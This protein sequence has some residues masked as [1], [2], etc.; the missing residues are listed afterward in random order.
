M[1]TK[2]FDERIYLA[3]SP[4]DKEEIYD[5]FLAGCYGEIDLGVKFSPSFI[6]K[7]LDLISYNCGLYDF[8]D[9]DE[10]YY[11]LD[12]EYY[13]QEEVNKLKHDMEDEE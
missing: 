7:N 1:S 11:E 6:L 8:F 12:G 3:L 9:N 2:V 10:D 4:V 13:L 5:D